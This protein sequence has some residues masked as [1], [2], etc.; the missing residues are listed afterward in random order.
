MF[1]LCLENQLFFS[2]SPV[3]VQVF[4]SQIGTADF[5][6]NSS[7]LCMEYFLFSSQW[8][9]FF[10]YWFG[11]LGLSDCSIFPVFNFFCRSNFG[12]EVRGDL[13]G[14]DGSRENQ[15]WNLFIW[16]YLSIWPN[17]PLVF[18]SIFI[19][20]S[21][22]QIHFKPLKISWLGRREFSRD[23]FFK[24]K[25]KIKLLVIFIVHQMDQ[26]SITRRHPI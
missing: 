10:A 26:N 6:L 12:L 14:D 20:S 18:L 4:S 11:N 2:V 25:I 19:A 8:L 15:I 7:D 13:D 9:I 23:F 21:E 24:S 5:L 1:D 22:F 17:I 3:S 16:F